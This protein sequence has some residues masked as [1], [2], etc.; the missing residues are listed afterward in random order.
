MDNGYTFHLWQRLF[1][2]IPQALGGI[3]LIADD[4]PLIGR[5]H[6]CATFVDHPTG[7]GQVLAFQHRLT[8]QD[9][10]DDLSEADGPRRITGRQF[11]KLMVY[12]RATPETG[13]V[14]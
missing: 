1:Q 13:G 10:D 4:V 9:Q 2:A 8:V 5:D 6:Q 14:D 11:L 7:D 3:C 12:A